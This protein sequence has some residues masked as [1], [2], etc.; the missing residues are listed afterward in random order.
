MAVRARCRVAVHAP[1]AVSRGCRVSR[2]SC[3]KLTTTNDVAPALS[4][5]E[6]DHLLTR[7]AGSRQ[8]YALTGSAAARDLPAAGNHRRTPP[9]AAV[10]YVPDAVD[11]LD[12]LELRRADSDANVMLVEPFDEVVYR[13]ATSTGEL[14]SVAPSQAVVD[15]LTGPGRSPE[16]AGQLLEVLG[17]E[18]EEWTR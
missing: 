14:H 12:A 3:R 10:L 4:P 6:V 15:L 17:R 18:D 8:P 5:R 11:A 16:E 1:Y 13:G 7:L 9:H 2:V